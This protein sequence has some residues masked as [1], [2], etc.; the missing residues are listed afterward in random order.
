[1]GGKIKKRSKLKVNKVGHSSSS[2][3]I[4]SKVCRIEP[5]WL[6]T[7]CPFLQE[8]ITDSERE[9]GPNI[10]ALQRKVKLNMKVDNHE[11]VYDVDGIML[12]PLA[13]CLCRRNLP[14]PIKKQ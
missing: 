10:S 8:I 2:K 7:I 6:F 11:E 14:A 5:L 13:H 3:S 9:D 12:H 1:M 4:K